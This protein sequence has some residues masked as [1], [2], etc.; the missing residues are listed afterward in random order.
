M[1]KCI[2]D[3][4][5]S[6]QEVG[7]AL[8][9]SARVSGN[10]AIRDSLASVITQK[11]ATSSND[12]LQM[13]LAIEDDKGRAPNRTR[14]TTKEKRVPTE[15]EKKQKDFDKGMAQKLF[16]KMI[17]DSSI[18][19]SYSCFNRFIPHLMNQFPTINH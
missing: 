17:I 3:D 14:N 4:N 13:Q 15:S 5:A 8:K 2:E 19:C 9:G 10:R 6:V 11:A 18:T 16:F 12:P 1:F 7:H